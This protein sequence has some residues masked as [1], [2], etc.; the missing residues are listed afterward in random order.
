MSEQDVV[1]P[2]GVPEDKLEEVKARIL[3]STA[4]YKARK[5]KQ[6]TQAA[7]CKQKRKERHKKRQAFRKLIDEGALFYKKNR[8]NILSGKLRLD[9]GFDIAYA[10]MKLDKQDGAPEGFYMC[11]SCYAIKAPTDKWDNYIAAGLIGLRLRDM[12]KW[13]ATIPVP[14]MMWESAQNMVK[15]AVE[16]IIK[17]RILLLAP[18]VPQRVLNVMF[19]SLQ[20]KFKNKGIA[21]KAMNEAQAACDTEEWDLARQKIKESLTLNGDDKETIRQGINIINQKEAVATG[22]PLAGPAET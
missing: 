9:D 14:T 22:N 12:T 1:V 3:A 16:N 11:R 10:I 20:K 19:G 15:E 13:T 6:D 18:E 7:I 8:A 17:S 5:A 4:K 2:A 21:V